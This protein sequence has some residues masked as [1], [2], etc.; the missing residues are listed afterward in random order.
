MA[1]KIDYYESLEVSRTASPDELKKAFRK[2][3][4]RYHPDRNP[5]DDA[6]E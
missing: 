6:A 5:G 1:I 4:M 3:A 2:Q